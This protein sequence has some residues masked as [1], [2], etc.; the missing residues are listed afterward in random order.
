MNDWILI[1][2]SALTAAVL[3]E[4]AL[5]A[6]VGSLFYLLSS[7]TE[8][9]LR[10]LVLMVIGWIVGY[11]LGQAFHGGGWAMLASILGSAFAVSVMLQMANSFNNGESVAPPFAGWLVD[12]Y[13]R[14]RK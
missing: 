1:S 8:T 12:M 2:L 9:G 10:K 3:P 6:S 5:G 4:I 14:I 11:A 13:V 7:N